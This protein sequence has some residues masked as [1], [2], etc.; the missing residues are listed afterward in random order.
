VRALRETPPA[1]A[2]EPVVPVPPV[3][4][5]LDGVDWSVRVE[6]QSGGPGAGPAGDASPPLLFV[7]FERDGD[8]ADTSGLGGWVVGTRLE[9]VSEAR[10]EAALREAKPWVEKPRADGFFE[11]EGGR[12]GR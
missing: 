12:R 6:G 1:P 2:E 3:V 5:S 11:D 7:R 9:D 8:E 4:V 10:L